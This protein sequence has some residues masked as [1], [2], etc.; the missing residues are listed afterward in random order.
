MRGWVNIVGYIAWRCL[1]FEVPPPFLQTWLAYRW[2]WRRK[3]RIF[4]PG[5]IISNKQHLCNCSDSRNSD[6]GAAAKICPCHQAP[7]GPSLPCPSNPIIVRFCRPNFYPRLCSFY[8]VRWTVYHDW[9]HVQIHVIATIPHQ[10]SNIIFIEVKSKYLV[11]R[12]RICFFIST[13]QRGNHV[14][15]Q[16]DSP[17]LGGSKADNNIVYY[18]I[19]IMNVPLMSRIQA[20]LG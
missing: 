12:M 16:R 5:E 14:I 3:L 20:D 2:R 18:A 1:R 15:S 13:H 11:S 10:N 8:R 9:A 4:W 7:W 17:V 19:N 6:R